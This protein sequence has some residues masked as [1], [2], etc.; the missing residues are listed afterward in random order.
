LLLILLL[1]LYLGWLPIS[2]ALSDGISLTRITGM[3]LVD[4]ALS[5]NWPA[6]KDAAL[7]LVMPALTLAAAPMAVIARQTRSAMLDVL[8]QD[9]LTTAR[10]KGLDERT[11]I[12]RHAL[13]NALLP[14]ITV[15]GLQLG[16]LLSGAIVTETVFARPGLGRL[17]IVS[18]QNRDYP[19][20]QGFVLVTLFV[21]VAVNVVVDV[22]YGILDPQVRLA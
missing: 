13:K 1:G 7:H 14:V 10:G 21:F 6:F 17:A 2:G 3:Y 11:L 12:V 15:V 5:G 22:I 20:V 9:Y 4:S 8:R 16:Y 18:I 19:V